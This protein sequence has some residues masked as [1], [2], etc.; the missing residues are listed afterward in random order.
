ML[1]MKFFWWNLGWN[2]LIILSV[3]PNITS[4]LW[5]KDESNNLNITLNLQT[6]FNNDIPGRS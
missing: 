2:K 4:F 3:N 1:L 6:P 5:L